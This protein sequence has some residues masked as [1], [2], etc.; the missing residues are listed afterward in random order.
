MHIPGLSE[1]TDNKNSPAV[2]YHIVVGLDAP[3]LALLSGLIGKIDLLS[4]KIDLLITQQ[5][6][7]MTQLSDALDTITSTINQLGVD[8][9]KALNDLQAAVAAA[10]ANSPDVTA[11]VSRL[12]TLNTQ[13]QGFDA[14]DVAAS[15]ALVPPVV[16]PPPPPATPT[17]A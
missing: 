6:N 4:N 15:A 11:A 2:A 1:H 14:A 12:Q 13:L 16:T 9:S 17:S 5:E 7:T 10:G 8:Q 3:T